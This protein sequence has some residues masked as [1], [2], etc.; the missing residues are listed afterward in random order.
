MSHQNYF[1]GHPLGKPIL[2]LPENINSV[3]R[4]MVVEFHD[5]NYTGE[6]F[7]FNFSGNL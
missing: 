4:E 5:L 2:G 3:T 6:N 7:F 1:R